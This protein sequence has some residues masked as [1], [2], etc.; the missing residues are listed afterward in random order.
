MVEQL[1]D[2]EPWRKSH[3]DTF[4]GEIAPCDHVI[5]I[6]ESDQKFIQMLSQFVCGGLAAGDG[7]IVIATPQHL[8]ALKAKVAQ[9]GINTDDYLNSQYFPL[10][11]QETL[12]KFMIGDQPDEKLFNEII[13]PLISRVRANKRKVRAFGEMVAVLW[14]EG[15]TGATVRL[16]QLWDKFC[17]NELF[18][19]FCA[20]PKSSFP[21][22]VDTSLSRICS[23]HSK[24][25]TPLRE[26][27]AEVL[28]SRLRHRS[29]V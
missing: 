18:C 24:I 23:S 28:Y 29:A 14:A 10:V 5:Q 25:V 3:A 17:Q 20:Y 4:W 26:G 2:G 13:A 1:R 21:H 22:D 12:A 7:V 19:L 8:D 16:E 6:Y 27:S 9:S 15:N 11:A